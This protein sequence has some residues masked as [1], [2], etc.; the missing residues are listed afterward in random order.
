MKTAYLVCRILLGLVFVV[1]GL[2]GFL[3][4]LPSQPPPGLAAEYVALM[5]RTGMF[6]A[7][8]GFQLL[9]GILVLLGIFTPLGL[10]ILAPI[11]V[12]I[13]MFHLFVEPSGLGVALFVF[14]LWLVVAHSRRDNFLPLLAR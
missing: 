6:T 12:N 11:I 3:H 5:V 7:I 13:L 9:G 4:F 1:F 2:N 10:V 8:F 14:L